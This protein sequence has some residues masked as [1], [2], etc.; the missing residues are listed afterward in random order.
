MEL[1]NTPVPQ[2]RVGIIGCGKIAHNHALQIADFVHAVVED[3]EPLVTGAE[4]SKAL[5]VVLAIYE[6]SRTG[7][8]V[9]LT[10]GTAPVPA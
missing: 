6:S 8:R 2:T 5:A 1:E 4:A 10:A 3:R 7:R 9:K